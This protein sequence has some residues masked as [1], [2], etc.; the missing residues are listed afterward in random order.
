[1]IE[2]VSGYEVKALGRRTKALRKK[3]YARSLSH[4]A[5]YY[6]VNEFPKSGGTWLSEM[7]AMAL[8]VP[9]RRSDSIRFERA[10]VHGHFLNPFGLRNVAAIFRDPRDLIVSLYYHSY[11]INDHANDLIVSIMKQRRPFDD[12]RDLP[13]NLPAFIRFI[14]TT[15]LFPR[16][17]WPSFAS[18]WIGRPDVTLTTYER[19]RQDCAG[20]LRRIATSLTGRAPPSERVEDAVRHFSLANAKQRH[21]RRMRPETEVPF[22]RAGSLGG[23]REHF[24]GEAEEMLIDH[25]YVEPMRRLGYE[26]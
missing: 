19:L 23:W 14:S 13:T 17:T 21:E 9:F 8:D 22:I 7:L 4:L 15:P 26:I 6:I 20:E 18:A 16:F 24:T 11:F 5:P 12:Y 3:V 2:T 25:G 10:I 1:M